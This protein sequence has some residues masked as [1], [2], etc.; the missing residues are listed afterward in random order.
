MY[1]DNMTCTG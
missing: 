1:Q